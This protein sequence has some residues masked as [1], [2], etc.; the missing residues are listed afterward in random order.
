MARGLYAA[1]PGRRHGRNDQVSQNY[2]IN[3]ANGATR[4]GLEE[5]AQS[6]VAVEHPGFNL[7]FPT[8]LNAGQFSIAATLGTEN[9]TR[10]RFH[11]TGHCWNPWRTRHDSNV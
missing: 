10:V 8:N 2:R 11:E 7:Q 3:L 6:D 9:G 1:P 5:T 4:H